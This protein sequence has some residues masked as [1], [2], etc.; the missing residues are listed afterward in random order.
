MDKLSFM[1]IFEVDE[2]SIR[3]KNDGAN[4]AWKK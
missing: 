1:D 3:H 2:A 4:A